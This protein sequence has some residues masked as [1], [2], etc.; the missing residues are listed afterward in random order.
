MT[1]TVIR[2]ARP[3][4]YQVSPRGVHAFFPQGDYKVPEE[5]SADIARR[6]L[7]SGIGREIR[8]KDSKPETKRRPAKKKRS[9]TGTGK[10]R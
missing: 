5:M 8:S 10:K 9:K 2:I 6:C 1:H 7:E 4:G 3:E